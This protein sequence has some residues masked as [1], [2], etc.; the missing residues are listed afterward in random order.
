MRAA[1]GEYAPST[2]SLCVSAGWCQC[3]DSASVDA[4]SWFLVG[5]AS[6]TESGIS[7]FQCGSVL[8][9]SHSSQVFRGNRWFDEVIIDI[10]TKKPPAAFSNCSSL[11]SVPSGAS[12]VE[13]SG[14]VGSWSL[15]GS[16]SETESGISLLQVGSVQVISQS[17]QGWWGG[18]SLPPTYPRPAPLT[19]TKRL[20]HAPWGVPG[21]GSRDAQRVRGGTSRHWGCVRMLHHIIRGWGRTLG[22]NLPAC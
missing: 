12:S 11:S 8:F 15:F 17:A 21:T 6:E 10:P 1:S 4:G 9:I 16:G 2:H 22:L 13:S 18:L 14:C 20:K 5:S 19:M 7:L 3:V